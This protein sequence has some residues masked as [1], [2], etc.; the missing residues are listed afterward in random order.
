M[1][2]TAASTQ[3]LCLPYTVEVASRW[4]PFFY[5][6]ARCFQKAEALKENGASELLS[7]AK[8]VGTYLLLYRPCDFKL[9]F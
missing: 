8:A 5:L 3:K 1:C 4:S 7:C 6:G 9:I 2:M